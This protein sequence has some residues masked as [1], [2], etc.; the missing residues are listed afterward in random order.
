MPWDKET[1]VVSN[2][3]PII[4]LSKI[5]QLGLIEKLYKKII[6]PGEV[7]KEL[8]VKGQEKE[9]ISAIKALIDG[10]I[11]NVH[12]VKNILSI[13]VLEKDLDPGE[14]AAIALA[15]ETNAAR[16][17]SDARH[18]IGRGFSRT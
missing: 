13:K 2:T 18:P 10:H 5:N 16:F 9:N 11:I 8:M 4:N 6:I 12:E 1:I 14:S 3:S 15:A 7:F 17:L